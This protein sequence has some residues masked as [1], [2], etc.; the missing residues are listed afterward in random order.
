MSDRTWVGEGTKAWADFN[1]CEY[2]TIEDLAY[3][4]RWQMPAKLG[5][6]KSS[7]PKALDL[8]RILDE[9]YGMKPDDFWCIWLEGEKSIE[10]PTLEQVKKYLGGKGNA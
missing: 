10:H 2:P 4:V 8:L 1:S 9:E 3:A 7:I 6:S 5:V